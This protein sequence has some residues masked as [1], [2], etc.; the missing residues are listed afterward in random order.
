M[1]PDATVIG[2]AGG[3]Y[4]VDGVWLLALGFRFGVDLLAFDGNL[5]TWLLNFVGLLVCVCLVNVVCLSR[6]LRK[7]TLSLGFVDLDLLSL[8]IL[9]LMEELRDDMVGP[10]EGVLFELHKRVKNVV[11]QLIDLCVVFE[12]RLR[13]PLLKRRLIWLQLSWQQLPSVHLRRLVEDVAYKA[14][15]RP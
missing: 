6:H 4:E 5:G 15:G 10:V 11:Q 1:I 9:K 13:E 8:K 2:I 3:Y 7:L 12:L 14:T